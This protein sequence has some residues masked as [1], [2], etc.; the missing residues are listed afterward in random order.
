MTDKMKRSTQMIYSLKAL[1]EEW[2]ETRQTTRIFLAE[3]SDEALDKKLPRQF[4]NT[5]KLQAEE[6]TIF[7]EDVIRSLE[8]RRLAFGEQYIETHG[9]DEYIY[10]NM[11][12]AALLKK[13]NML[14]TNL[15]QALEKLDG[16]EMIDYYGEPRNVHQIISSL[17]SHEAMHIGQIIAFCY[18]VGI[19]IPTAITEPMA[20]EG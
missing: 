20:L 17:T 2:K 16:T 19:E 8:T 18:T 13:M 6:L 4:L 11:S 1:L 3:L 5:I 10:T 12:R 9:S 7:Q 14:D 15:T